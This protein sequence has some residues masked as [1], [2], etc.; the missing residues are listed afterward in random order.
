MITSAGCNY[1]IVAESTPKQWNFA[2]PPVQV[3]LDPIDPRPTDSANSKFDLLLPDADSC[4]SCSKN[5]TQGVFPDAET[6]KKWLPFFLKDNPSAKC[7]KG[8]HAA[9]AQVPR[10]I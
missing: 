10:V 1:P 7:S 6:F 8:G 9:Y 4:D 5:F 3:S 2:H